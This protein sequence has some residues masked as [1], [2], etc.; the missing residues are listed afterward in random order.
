MKQ[1]IL[2]FKKNAEKT[3]NKIRVPQKAIDKMGN[4]FYM[5]VYDDKII[6]IPIKKG[7]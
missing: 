6:L 2:K 1:P 4:E 5:E 7:A 3:T